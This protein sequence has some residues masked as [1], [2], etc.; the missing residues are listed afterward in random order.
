M[1]HA[2]SP[3]ATAARIACIAG[4]VALVGCAGRGGSTATS[5]NATTARP[6]LASHTHTTPN[7]LANPAVDRR[8]AR[9]ARLL[10][11]DFPSG[12]QETDSTSE[13][14]PSEQLQRECQGVRDAREA[15]SARDA[16]PRFSDDTDTS[17]VGSVTYVYADEPAAK[18]AYGQ[19]TSRET[20]ICAA[21]AIAK[22]IAENKNFTVGKPQAS[23]IAIDPLGDERQG[24][25][26]MLTVRVPY[27][28]D[29]REDFV[30]V[31]L[32]RGIANLQFIS[33]LTPFD[34]NLREDLTSKVVRRLSVG[35]K[36]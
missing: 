35:L 28:I 9:R 10:L 20:R 11:T 3:S 23:R 32:G 6:G 8:I 25:Q 18:E 34:D 12:W 21:E 17:A 15:V 7:V 26:I 30:V 19:L 36:G 4:L 5:S 1:F 24:S 14:Q 33:T 2:R 27:D 29:H 22:G 31:R 16:S 13:Q